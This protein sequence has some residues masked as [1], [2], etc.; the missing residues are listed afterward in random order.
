MNHMKKH[1]LF[2]GM[3]L[4]AAAFTACTEDFTD[5]ASPQSN[6]QGE[7]EP[8]YAINFEEAGA[9]TASDVNVTVTESNVLTSQKGTGLTVAYL[10]PSNAKELMEKPDIDGGLIGGASLKAADFK[11][12][13][14]AWK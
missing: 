12:I 1:I 14:D 9:A 4:C 11:G 5:W 3:L 7:N 13:I 2:G 6:A 10:K 8:A